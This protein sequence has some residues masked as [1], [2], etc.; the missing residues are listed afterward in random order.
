MVRSGGSA[1]GLSGYERVPESQDTDTSDDILRAHFNADMASW[2][3]LVGMDCL[4]DLRDPYL[5]DEM[6]HDSA[7]QSFNLWI[8]QLDLSIDHHFLTSNKATEGIN[9]MVT[10]TIRVKGSWWEYVR[11]TEAGG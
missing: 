3:S 10:C 8:N 6:S 2:T 5:F 9:H 4:D 1:S 11:R 7:M